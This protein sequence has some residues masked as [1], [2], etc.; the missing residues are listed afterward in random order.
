MS[1]K[2]PPLVT[3]VVPSYNHAP[4]IERAIESLIAIE[5]DRIELIVIDDGSSDDSAERVR[6]MAPR[7]ERRFERFELVARENR[8]LTRTLNQALEWARGDYFVIADS[9][10]MLMPNHVP[11]LLAVLE[12][13]PG[14]AAAYGGG[15]MVDVDDR[16]VREMRPRERYNDFASLLA[17]DKEIIS[18]GGMIRT[19][20]L[21]AAGGYLE[22]LYIEDWYIMLRL[23]ER[24]ARLKTVP[25]PVVRY[26]W[27]ETNISRNV[28]RMLD[29][30]LTIL[31]LFADHPGHRWRVALVH[32]EAALGHWRQSRRRA[33]SQLKIALRAHPG[34]AR[35]PLF[36]GAVGRLL[37]PTV[38][39]DVARSFRSRGKPR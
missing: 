22:G 11:T 6:A 39:V 29:A 24:G 3:I 32:V 31:N 15:V 2:V 30:R 36:V 26:R 25:V 14:L 12:A 8:G 20:A 19:D 34:I 17:R 1:S 38:F 28:D 35:H 18:S 5:H 10:D 23:T 33:L 9:D 16:F 37:L 27:H 21:R 7:C 4:F 13:E